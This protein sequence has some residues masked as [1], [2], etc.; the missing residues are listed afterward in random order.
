MDS[1]ELK[2]IAD[3]ISKNL[4][5]KNFNP[6]DRIQNPEEFRNKDM[7][8]EQ[9]KLLVDSAHKIEDRR[10]GSNN[11]FIGINTILVSILVHLEQ[12]GRVETSEMLLV[13]VLTFVGVLIAFDWL[14]VIE[15]Y[16]KMNSLNYSL[17]KSFEN[18]LPTYVFSLRG[19]MEAEQPHAQ[20]GTRANLILI[21]ENLLPKVFLLTY[22]IY[23]SVVLTILV[24]KFV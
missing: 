4:I 23:F 5:N 10:G 1:D 12:L 8:F 11:I 13:P 9:Y 21:S 14:K 20:P 24:R 22:S 18:F 19:K 16:K 15:S 2:L 3:E 7:M 6:S 17:I